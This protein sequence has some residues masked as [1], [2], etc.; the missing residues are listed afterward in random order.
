M[1][2]QDC[3]LVAQVEGKSPVQADLLFFIDRLHGHSN[4]TLPNIKLC[5]KH[6]HLLSGMFKKNDMSTDYKTFR[7]TCRANKKN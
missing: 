6:I 2:L 5:C 7:S 3:A 4:G 1:K